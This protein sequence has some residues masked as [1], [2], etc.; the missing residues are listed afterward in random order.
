MHMKHII[1]VCGGGVKKRESCMPDEKKKIVPVNTLPAPV[2]R[3]VYARYNI[4]NIL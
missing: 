3:N 2:E 4:V 1:A